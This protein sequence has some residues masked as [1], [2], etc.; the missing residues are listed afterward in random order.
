MSNAF[1][2]VM[3]IPEATPE[4]P[5]DDSVDLVLDKIEPRRSVIEVRIPLP[6]REVRLSDKPFGITDVVQQDVV[7]QFVTSYCDRALWLESVEKGTTHQV[8]EELRK[9]CYRKLGIKTTLEDREIL[10]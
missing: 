5:Y 10:K 6:P 7:Q 2:Q 1:R 8:I 9:A 3:S 4:R